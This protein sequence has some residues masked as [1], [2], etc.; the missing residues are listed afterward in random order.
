M[1]VTSLHAYTYIHVKRRT[2]SC[3]GCGSSLKTVITPRLTAGACA[4]VYVPL[5]VRVR[6][7]VYAYADA[8]G[9]VERV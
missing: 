4:N 6:P 7:F 1:H 9:C 3:I 8:R 2:L 5:S